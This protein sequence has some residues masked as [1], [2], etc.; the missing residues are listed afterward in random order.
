MNLAAL[1]LNCDRA[2]ALADSASQGPRVVPLDSDRAELPLALALDGRTPEVG[3]AGLELCRRAP[4]LVCVDFLPGL[5]G[6]SIWHCGRQRLDA[7]SALAL[8]FER[9]RRPLARARGVVLAVPGYLSREQIRLAGKLAQ[10]AGLP[11][12][13]AIPR[14]LSAGLSSYGEH[15]WHNV[16]VVVD[17]DSHA[18]VCAVLR[19]HERE[20]RVLGQKVLSAMGLRLWKERLLAGMAEQCIRQSRRDPRESPDAE[21]HLYDQLDEVLERC[22]RNQPATLRVQALEWFQTLTFAPAEAT[23]ACF[24]L[25]RRAADEI[26][27]ALAWAEEQLTSA[28]VYLTAGAARLPGLAAAVYR[29]CENKTP[30]LV[31]PADGPARAAL[32]LAQRIDQG[33]LEPGIFEPAAPLPAD[34]G[35]IPPVLPFPERRASWK[36]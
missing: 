30:V 12:T 32:Q 26:Y 17:V 36:E 8:A 25:A 28:T 6:E 3:R 7:D 15:P 34:R 24:E 33:D 27:A 4:H 1:D 18:L 9:I 29:R 2:W 11:V 10:Q 20:L 13:G 16:G 35:E 23:A 14:V 22:G 21:Q 31:L 5:G 19:P